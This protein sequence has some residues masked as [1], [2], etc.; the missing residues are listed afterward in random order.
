MFVL[1][2]VFMIFSLSSSNNI[3]N[4]NQDNTVQLN[5][6]SNITMFNLNE[7]TVGF[8]VYF[9]DVIKDSES[10]AIIRTYDSNNELINIYSSI[11]TER[12]NL[13]TFNIG[14]FNAN[15]LVIKINND[16]YINANYINDAEYIELEYIEINT[17]EEVIFYEPK[18]LYGC[19]KI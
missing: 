3:N 11:N 9:E 1:L 14:T 16:L 5:D 6:L 8:M 15:I 4:N 12:T 13:N 19:S 10:V 2:S 17:N 7:Y 18:R